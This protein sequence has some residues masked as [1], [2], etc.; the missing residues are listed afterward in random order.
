MDTEDIW[1]ASTAWMANFWD[2]L[3]RGV[4]II[5][6]IITSEPTKPDYSLLKG[7]RAYGYQPS[8]PAPEQKPPQG[9]SG[10]IPYIAPAL[11]AQSCDPNKSTYVPPINMQ[12]SRKATYQT[13]LADFVNWGYS[14]EEAT[15]TLSQLMGFVPDENRAWDKNDGIAPC[16]YD[17]L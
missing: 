13:V 17:E 16:G 2:N 5:S 12:E 11:M 8:N 15:A 4:R 10:I 6:P 14:A 3:V 1:D 7:V 9:A